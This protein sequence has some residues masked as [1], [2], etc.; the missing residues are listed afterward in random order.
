MAT[1]LNMAL[2]FSCYSEYDVNGNKYSKTVLFNT[3]PMY[4]V[5]VLVRQDFHQKKASKILRNISFS[6]TLD[7]FPYMSEDLKSQIKPTRDHIFAESKV[8]VNNGIRALEGSPTGEYDLVSVV[9]HQGRSI[10]K[11]H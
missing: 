3:L 8:V 1:N 2:Q 5:T 11:G 10:D 6:T 7:L 9:T 4:L